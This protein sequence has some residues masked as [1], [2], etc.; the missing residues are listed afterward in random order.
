MD[1]FETSP[2]Q[3]ALPDAQDE[4]APEPLKSALLDALPPIDTTR[5]VTRRKASVVHAVLFGAISIE[6]A[7]ARYELSVEEF[8]SWHRLIER[9]GVHGLRSTRLQDYRDASRRRD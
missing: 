4:T 9:H 7:C 3:T 5:W 1:Q 8:D 6:D 2:S